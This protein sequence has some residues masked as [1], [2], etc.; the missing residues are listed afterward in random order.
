MFIMSS[1]KEVNWDYIGDAV[2]AFLTIIMIPLTYK[3]VLRSLTTACC[4]LTNFL[5]HCLRCHCGNLLIY[6]HQYLL[7]HH[8]QGYW[9]TY[10]STSVRHGREVESSPRWIHASLDV[11][12]DQQC[13][14]SH[15][16]RNPTAFYLL[17]FAFSSTFDNRT[18]TD[19]KTIFVILF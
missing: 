18:G 14:V 17:T 16:R 3:C 15:L 2:P 1:V 12:V 5:Q 6:I 8:P 9:W 7:I 10:H 4:R 13:L 19:F 11:C